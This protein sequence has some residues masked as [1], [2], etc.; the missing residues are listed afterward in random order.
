M[1]YRVFFD[2]V[3]PWAPSEWAWSKLP[4]VPRSLSKRASPMHYCSLVQPVSIPVHPRIFHLAEQPWPEISCS[5]QR[6]TPGS[7]ATCQVLFPAGPDVRPPRR[8]PFKKSRNCGTQTSRAPSGSRQ[9]PRPRPALAS[10][11]A[12]TWKTWKPSPSLVPPS[13]QRSHSPRS[14]ASPTMSVLRDTANG[15]STPSKQ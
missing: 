13:S 15:K 4:W 6:Q 1:L 11:P 9:R 5:W 12:V 8:V 2:N 3:F 10:S 7:T 14:L